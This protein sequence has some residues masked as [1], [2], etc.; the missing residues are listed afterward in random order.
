M[1]Y[2][3]GLVKKEIIEIAYSWKNIGFVLLGVAVFLYLS[4]TS[5]MII[6]NTNNSCYMITLLIGIVTSGQFLT[7][8]IFSDKRNQTFEI[9]F[10]MK[11]SLIIMLSKNITMMFVGFVPFIMFYIFFLMHGYNIL[12]NAWE[13]IKT[14]LYFWNGCCLASICVFLSGDEKTASCMALP[15]IGIIIALSYGDYIIKTNYNINAGI[16]ISLSS[17]IISTVFCYRFYTKT[18]FFLKI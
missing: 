2:F 15:C 7:E 8:S 13:I 1:R 6:N 17:A 10:V 4:A 9:N 12:D 3:L 16:I 11:K 14:L 5:D 18:K